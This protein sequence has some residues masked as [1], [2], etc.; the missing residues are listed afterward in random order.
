MALGFK[1]GGGGECKVLELV[2]AR[3]IRYHVHVT[4]TWTRLNTNFAVPHPAMPATLHTRTK[5][6]RSKSP[7]V[8][9]D[10][11]PP[12]QGQHLWPSQEKHRFRV[13]SRGSEAHPLRHER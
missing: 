12:H 5:Q 9:C 4:Y 11:H 8:I 7:T 3:L 1:L 6:V 2:V 10:S 13:F